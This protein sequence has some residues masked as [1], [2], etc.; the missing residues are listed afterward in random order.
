L[1]GERKPAGWE[2]PAWN[3]IL[4]DEI[5]KQAKDWFVGRGLS[6]GLL[7]KRIN[8]ILLL[9]HFTSASEEL[10]RRGGK[11][12]A[13]ESF[14]RQVLSLADTIEDRAWPSG[15]LQRQY[16]DLPNQLRAFSTSYR[17]QVQAAT[18]REQNLERRLVGLIQEIRHQV[19]QPFYEHLAILLT[20]AL[21]ADGQ[22]EVTGEYLRVV[23]HRNPQFRDSAS[24]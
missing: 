2:P 13:Q 10:R 8:Q 17:Q 23:Y 24:A 3:A 9:K 6:K 11:R 14:C 19:R 22:E 20:A 15:D 4:R 12:R 7:R 5:V 18:R 16:R 1:V 21:Q